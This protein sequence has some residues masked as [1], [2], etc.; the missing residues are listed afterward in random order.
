MKKII[1]SLCTILIMGAVQAQNTTT[2]KALV[3]KMTL[4]EKVNLVVGMGMNLPGGTG[5]G[6]CQRT[7]PAADR[8]LGAG[9]L[10]G[11]GF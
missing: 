7:K 10:V 1:T 11:G 3:A 8:A 9:R 2:A 5:G 6:H 4:E